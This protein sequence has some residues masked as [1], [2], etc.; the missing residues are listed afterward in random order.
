MYIDLMPEGHNSETLQG[1][2]RIDEQLRSRIINNINI[3]KNQEKTPLDR[4]IR[5]FGDTFEMVAL[6]ENHL[7]HPETQIQ[8]DLRK[9]IEKVYQNAEL[10]LGTAHERP[11]KPDSISVTFDR[12][13][14]LVID[15]V[16]ELKSSNNAFIHG[17][18]KEQPAKTLET[19]GAVVTILNRLKKGEETS[20]ILPKD[21]DLSLDKRIKRDVELKKIK[22]QVLLIAGDKGPITFSPDM[23]YR[24]IVPKGEELPTFNSRLLEEFG[25]A[26]TLK[27]SHSDFSKK[28]I[29]E[30]INKINSEESIYH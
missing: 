16:V 19:I 29:H 30:I 23:I 10:V 14:K 22:G 28:D 24:I 6:A 25:Y 18:K 3:V 9:L 12:Q 2:N 20:K 1:N 11:S 5:I 7:N 17:L 13:G 26:V 27:I 21:S 15:E 4:E 8:Q